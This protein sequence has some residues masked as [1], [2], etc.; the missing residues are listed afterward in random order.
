MHGDTGTATGGSIS[1]IDSH[2]TRP[3]VI[4]EATPND[5]DAVNIGES[6][7]E[8]GK[9]SLPRSA[10]GPRKYT[11]NRDCL[12]DDGQ[13]DDTANKTEKR[14]HQNV[15]INRYSI[16]AWP[17]ATQLFVFPTKDK[18]Y[19]SYLS[20]SYS[21][22]RVDGNQML[23]PRPSSPGKPSYVYRGALSLCLFCCKGADSSRPAPAAVSEEEHG[24][25]GSFEKQKHC[26][27]ATADVHNSQQ[28]SNEE[29]RRGSA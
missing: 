3:N 7:A 20:K 10:R 5:P 28:N 9:H 18:F 25:S 23:R 6:A 16:V 29:A 1:V 21:S 17:F 4:A 11:H 27:S 12:V 22:D 8:R 19:S 2:A 26:R 15:K 13:A 24:Y 14:K